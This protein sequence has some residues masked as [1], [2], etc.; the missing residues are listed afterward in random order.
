MDNKYLTYDK[1]E[2]L[3]G[4]VPSKSFDILEYKAEKQIDALS[5]G[6]FKNL[7]EYPQELEMCVYE[8]VNMFYQENNAG[9]I[10]SET[11]GNYSVTYK[12]ESKQE[13]SNNV[14]NTIQMWLLDT[15]VDGVPAL[16]SGVDL[17]ENR[18]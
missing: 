4:T 11:D 7:E 13:T 3:G 10:A 14:R 12:S 1:Y 6:R 9:N 17:N 5:F 15:K 2:E 8:L 16:Y 18:Y